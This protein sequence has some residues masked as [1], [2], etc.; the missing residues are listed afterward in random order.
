MRTFLIA[1][2]AAVFGF[3]TGIALAPGG[4]VILGENA[5]LHGATLDGVTV[6]ADG[7]YISITNNVIISPGIEWRFARLW[8]WPAKQ[9][10]VQSNPMSP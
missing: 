5:V 6:S 8:R 2:V 9:P 7:K 10:A 4:T 3:G 1:G